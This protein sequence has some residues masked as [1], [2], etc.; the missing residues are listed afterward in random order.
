MVLCGL[1]LVIGLE[2]LPVKVVSP[3]QISGFKLYKKNTE[4]LHEKVLGG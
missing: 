1:K 3:F 2:K 4:V